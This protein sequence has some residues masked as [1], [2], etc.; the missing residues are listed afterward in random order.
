[1]QHPTWIVEASIGGSDVERRLYEKSRKRAAR[2]GENWKKNAVNLNAICDEFAPDSDGIISGVKMI[3]RGERYTVVA[4][5]ASGYLRIY[6]S[7]T[8]CHVRLDV[9]PSQ[10]ENETHF[11]IKKREE[12]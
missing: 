4:D 5:M 2:F 12:M 7:V 9:T 10:K 6:D 8:R 1:M 11:I 3:F